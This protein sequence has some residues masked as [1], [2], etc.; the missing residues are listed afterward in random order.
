MLLASACNI[1]KFVPA[2]DALYTGASFKLEN[3][4]ASKKENKVN[5]SDLEALLRP[6]PN[7]SLFGLRFKLMLYNLAGTKQNF[8]SKFLRKM[9]EPPVLLSSVNLDRNTQMLTN[10]LENR[11]FFHA[12]VTGDTTIKDKKASATYVAN[13]GVQYKIDEVLFSRQTATQLPSEIQNTAAT[14]YFKKR[15][16][17]QPRCNKG[18]TI[19]H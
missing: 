7:A 17:I 13:A 8:I 9:G 3:S 4:N 12:N 19:A 5:K 2:G 10:T 18:R 14:N 6:K 1:T 15:R 11:G 16:C